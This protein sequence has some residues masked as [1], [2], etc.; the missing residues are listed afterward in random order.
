MAEA[1]SK[2]DSLL[3]KILGLLNSF[4]VFLSIFA[5]YAGMV[6]E[7]GRGSGVCMDEGARCAFQGEC[8]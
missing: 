4:E 2:F 6:F 5:C 3:S 7:R 1:N 8:H